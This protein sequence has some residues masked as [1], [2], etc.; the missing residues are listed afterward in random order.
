MHKRDFNVKTVKI[1]ID[2]FNHMYIVGLHSPGNKFLP[3]QLFV[4]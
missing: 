4:H 2:I 1:Q 3:L